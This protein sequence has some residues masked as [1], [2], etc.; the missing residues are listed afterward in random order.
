M[1]A[2][3]AGTLARLKAHRAELFDPKISEHGGRI[4]KLMGDGTLVE[5]A[6]VVNAVECAVAIQSALAEG[7]GALQL[8]IGINL[9]DVMIDG[10]DVYG[11]GVNVA[12]RLEACAPTGG[13][14]ISDM[15]HENVKG[16]LDVA[17]SSLGALELKNIERP[18]NAWQWLHSQ[19]SPD[20]VDALALPDRPSI[21]V[22]PFN[23]MSGDPDQEYFSD[24]ISE[25]IITELSRFRE[26]FVIARNSSFSYKGK[27]LK[28]QDIGRDLGVAYIVEGSVRK[29]GN[30]VRV[31]AQLIEAASGN[32]IWAEKYDRELQDIFDLQDEIT[33]SIVTLLPVR[34]QGVLTEAAR[35]K[36]SE[37]LSAYDCYLQGRWLFDQSGGQDP[38]ATALLRKAVEIDP[39]CAHAYAYLAMAQAYSLYT[40]TPIGVDPTASALENVERSLASGDG[41][42]LIHAV[43]GHT[44]ILAG[45][46]DLADVHSSKAVTLNPND[47]FALMSRGYVVT[48]LG[49][50]A[51]GVEQ[52]T[53][54]LRYDPH[55]PEFFHEQFAEANYMLGNYEKA[56][57]IYT[58]WRNR[59]LHACIPL[60]AN[61][62]QLGRMDEAR[63]AIKT[64]EDQLAEDADFTFYASTHA[65]MCK[66]PEDAE[67]WLDGYRKIGMTT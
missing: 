53:R 36:P 67:H 25:D 8:R 39:E 13:I 3:E 62:A 38:Q 1:A 65:R 26:L 16:K 29:A 34:L 50:P 27:S 12:A 51:A 28:V 10:D 54:A 48:Y 6:S 15:V 17:F 21:A 14:C 47:L 5:F 42:H 9:G 30:R 24:G 56:V 63:A 49:D 33:R 58:R 32:H 11:D 52:L 45:L 66:R 60:A 18:V 64:F 4:V 44:Y 37:N 61:Y 43:A 31:T 22:L 41:D 2:D 40:V 35:R 57:E 59:P 55:T 23:N 7:D 20:T 46:H 19:A